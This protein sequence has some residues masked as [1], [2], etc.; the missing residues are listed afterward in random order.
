[1]Q[2][3]ALKLAVSEQDLNDLLRKYLPADH[4]IEDLAVRVAEQGLTVSGIYPLFI[5]VHFETLWRLGLEQG[6]V[7]ARLAHF[8]AMGVPGNI[9]KSAIM[10]IVEDLAS[11][12]EWI[13]VAGD[14]LRIDVDRCLG[15]YAFPT[16]THLKLL[17][18]QTG[19]IYLEGG[20]K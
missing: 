1:M 12:E 11:A 19:A 5:N 8:K 13:E 18:C 15:Q 9:F 14:T 6:R 3:Y 4:P 2:V 7:T 17:D 10:K 16:R 20:E